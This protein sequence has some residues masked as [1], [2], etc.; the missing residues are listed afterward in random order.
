MKQKIGEIIGREQPNFGA[1]MSVIVKL[2]TIGLS[3]APCPNCREHALRTLGE[4]LPD[5]GADAATLAGEPRPWATH[6]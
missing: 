4:M 6:H 3:H 5:F 2:L 1:Q